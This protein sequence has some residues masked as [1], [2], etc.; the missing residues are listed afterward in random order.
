MIVG[1]F[2]YLRVKIF[3]AGSQFSNS[4]FVQH[5]ACL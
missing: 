4:R 3:E 2:V 5:F 1:L